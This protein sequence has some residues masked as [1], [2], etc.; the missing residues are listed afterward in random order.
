MPASIAP[1]RLSVRTAAA[2]FGTGGAAI[3]LVV[4]V[5]AAYRNEQRR[6]HDGIEF[7]GVPERRWR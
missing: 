1:A 2:P 3:V 6:K 4:G 7:F 5:A